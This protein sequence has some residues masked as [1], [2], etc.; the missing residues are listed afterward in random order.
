MFYCAARHHAPT[1]AASERA[2]AT[3][4]SQRGV[5]SRNLAHAA[6]RPSA[7]PA[8][9]PKIGLVLVITGLGLSVTMV[10]LPLGLPIGLAGVLV[11]LWGLF[12]TVG[13]GQ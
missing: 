4:C 1:S 11:G 6:R 13:S 9:K 8:L 10:G 5:C 3:C 12:G 2:P 7:R